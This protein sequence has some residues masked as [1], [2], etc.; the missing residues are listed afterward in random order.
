MTQAPHLQLIA[1]LQAQIHTCV[2][3]YIRPGQPVAYLD[4]PDIKNCGDSAIWLGQ[5]AY[6]RDQYGMQ[7]AYICRIKDFSRSTMLRRIGDGPIFL[8][9]GGNFG[10]IWLGHQKFRE[11]ILKK[12]PS[13][14][15]V[16]FAQSIHFESREHLESAKRCIGEHKNF[17][18]MVRDKK[19]LQFAQQHFD[20]VVKLCPDMAFCIGPVATDNPSLKVLAVLRQDKEKSSRVDD[21]IPPDIPCED[22]MSE[23]KMDV[24]R[25]KCAGLKSAIRDRAFSDLRSRMLNAAA[26]HRFQRGI[27][28]IARARA[29]V[30]DRLHVHICSLLAGKPHAVLDNNY[31]KVYG[32]MDTFS[33]G[34]ALSYKAATL[35]EAIAWARQQA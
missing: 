4:F 16:Q 30:T 14:Q 31:G 7:P 1:E 26:N 35:T 23:S 6:L 28:H 20:C 5:I 9:G 3:E 18:L 2:K 33:G 34:T 22:W 25:A 32:F 15:V 8:R 24:R 17:V 11:M 21:E 29:I 13:H 12:H 10:D 19:S 27:Q